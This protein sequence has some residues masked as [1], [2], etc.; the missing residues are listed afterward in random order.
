M[1]ENTKMT[2]FHVHEDNYGSLIAVECQKDIPFDI[3]RIYYIYAVDEKQRRGFHSHRELRQALICVHGSVTIL[4]K[5]PFGE[6]NICLDNPSKA[7]LF[8]PMVWREMYD[9]SEDAVLLVL[10]SEHYDEKDYIRDYTVYENE[11]LKFFAKKC[12]KL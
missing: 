7:L 4:A 3:K 1:V 9:F 11:A 10:A 6:E 5:T 2:Q 12:E 8:E